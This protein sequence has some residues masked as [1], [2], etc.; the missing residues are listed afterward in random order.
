M[1]PCPAHAV[2]CT[3]SG[4]PAVPCARHKGRPEPDRSRNLRRGGRRAA[5]PGA[6][7]PCCQ[8]RAEEGSS[9]QTTRARAR[10]ARTSGGGRAGGG[11]EQE[12]EAEE[13]EAE[14]EEEHLPLGAARCA[15]VEPAADSKISHCRA[16]VSPGSRQAVAQFV[17]Q[18]P[19]ER[20]QIALLSVAVQPWRTRGHTE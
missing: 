2:G 1:P 15:N 5:A 3:A 6:G 11:G 17:Q 12:E 16:A 10:G 20:A 13:E 4:H 9:R 8:R 18:A 14:E 19:A 7:R